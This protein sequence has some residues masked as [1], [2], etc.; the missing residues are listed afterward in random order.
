MTTRYQAALTY[1]DALLA[2]RAQ[3]RAIADAADRMAMAYAGEMAAK[4]AGV[5]IVGFPL[6]DAYQALSVLLMD[7]VPQPV[8]AA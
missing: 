1:I 2:D 4:S 3:L 5:E 8:G 6:L 7:R